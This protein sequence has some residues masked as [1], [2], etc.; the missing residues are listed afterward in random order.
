[1]S[2]AGAL[3]QDDELSSLLEDLDDINDTHT[4]NDDL[5]DVVSMINQ[6]AKP[7]KS[8]KKN[9]L[10]EKC[11]EDLNDIPDYH[12]DEE[13]PEEAKSD[14]LDDL[15]KDSMHELL[16]NYRKDRKDNDDFIKFLWER[17]NKSH[18]DRIL[19]ESLTASIRTKSETNSNLLKLI[20]L[21]IK[22]QNAKG[23]GASDLGDLDLE[24]LLSD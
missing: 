11:I 5:D 19:F 24:D 18:P 20:D 14:D 12:P 15:C 22:K 8:K 9:F 16:K 2:E 13:M 23:G 1:M 10:K 7:A 4:D 6:P 21:V 17:L 3:P